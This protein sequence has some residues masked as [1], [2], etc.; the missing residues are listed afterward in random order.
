[1]TTIETPAPAIT[2]PRLVAALRATARVASA[3]PIIVG[4]FVL[5]GWWSDIEL[6]KRIVPGLV[7]INLSANIFNRGRTAP[8][9]RPSSPWA[10]PS[11][12]R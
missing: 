4:I 11:D 3:I 9:S 5:F 6:L 1:M 10:T 7:A 8:S 12:C 2:L